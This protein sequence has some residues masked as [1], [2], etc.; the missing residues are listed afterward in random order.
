MCIYFNRQNPESMVQRPTIHFQALHPWWSPS[1][2]G[3]PFLDL[4]GP[5][6]DYYHPHSCVHA[7]LI[8]T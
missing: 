8:Q 7:L 4:N 6:S 1:P 2:P 3:P 5:A